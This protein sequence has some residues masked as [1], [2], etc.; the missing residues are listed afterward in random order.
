MRNPLNKVPGPWYARFSSLR[1]KWAVISGRRVHYVQAL[2][3]QYG[4]YVRISPT[5]IAV[6]DPKAFAQIHSVKAGFEKSKWYQ[7]FVMF[8]RLTLFTMTDTKM[9][10]GR[11]RMFA[12]AFS[13]TQ[14][15]QHWQSAVREKV[16]L[17]V[18]RIRR[19]ALEGTADVLKWWTFMASD[20]SAELMF[21]ESFNTLETGQVPKSR[22]SSPSRSAQC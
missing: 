22:V 1:L 10:A 11:R 18:D 8:E 20:V 6:A 16:R 4:P 5:E 2:H 17:A 19:D 7:D 3:E 14:L 15:R 21:G 13:K 12:R 9:H